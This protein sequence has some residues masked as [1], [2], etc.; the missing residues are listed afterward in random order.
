[1]AALLKVFQATAK[2]TPL[3]SDVSTIAVTVTGLFFYQ[4]RLSAR[5]SLDELP[6]F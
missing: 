4:E 1:M 5:M 2:I 6:G 3:N